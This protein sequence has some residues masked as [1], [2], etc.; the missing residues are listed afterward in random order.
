MLK[1]ILCCLSLFCLWNSYAQVEF[2]GDPEPVSQINSSSGE[3]YL[4]LS[5]NEQSIFFTRQNHVQNSNGIAD[6]GDIWRS[7]YDSAWRSPVDLSTNDKYLATP[8]GLI[9]DGNYF[10]Y[11]KVWYD[12]GLYYGGV[13]AFNLDKP[14]KEI[15]INIPFFKNNSPLQTGNLSADGRRLLLSME[16]G[17]GYG[18]DDLFVCFLK[19][20]GSWSYPK[21][22]GHQINTRFQEITPFLAADNKT[23]FFASNGRGGEG[24]FDLFMAVRL[25]DTWQHWSEPINLGPK[26]NSQGAET[27]F[28]FKQ[29]SEYAYFVSTQNSDGYGD[30]RRIKIKTEVEEAVAEGPITE[31][32]VADT[33]FEHS[34]NVA[35]P[36]TF[37][38]RNA[39]TS[40]PVRCVVTHTIINEVGSEDY[41]TFPDSAMAQLAVEVNP[42][43][44]WNLRFRSRGFLS[45]EI[46]FGW[47]DFPESGGTRVIELEPLESGNTIM[48]KSVLFYRGAANFVEGSEHELRL[49]V[50]MLKENPEINI[51]L[52]G[53]TDNV[54]NPIMNVQLSQ[55]RVQ[56]VKDFL[57]KNDISADRI[58]GKGY[59]G[60]EPIVSNESEETRK[61][62]RRVEFEI[63]RD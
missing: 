3:N 21:N 6:R 40:D 49:V 1:H 25:D 46:S 23:L 26:V 33:T 7:D 12:K 57:I 48:L 16:N 34:E 61:L 31:I 17:S 50:E 22:L 30:V 52:K 62:N 4:Y 27:S 35:K 47:E 54:G 5:P 13:F 53:H 38:F 37:I 55:Q 8:L 63:R 59:G 36:V 39:K 29:G 19:A 51:F 9:A 15:E 45:E 58:S 41:R 60:S 20:D 18:V 43:E 11:N 14:S 10:L 32:L 28:V 42:R 24:S 44:V 56:A 2:F